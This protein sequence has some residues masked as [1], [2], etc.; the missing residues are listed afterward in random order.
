M[1]EDKVRVLFLVA[2]LNSGGIE[3]YLLRYLDYDSGL[4]AFVLCKTGE[5][6]DL[7]SKYMR[8]LG[9]NAI[10]KLKIGYFDIFSWI[11]LKRIIKKN[12]IDIVCDF[13]GNFAGIPMMIS[14][15]AGVSKRYTFYRGSTN[16]F[17]EDIFRL[18][19]NNWVRWLVKRYATR[20]LSNSEAAL[21]FFY[22]GWRVHN[23]RFDVI[24]N[25]IDDNFFL[26]EYDKRRVRNEL[27]IPQEAFVVGHTGRY[28]YAKN[29]KTIL[30][31]AKRLC[32][33]HKLLYFVLIGKG[34]EAHLKTEVDNWGL[35]EQIRILGYRD[36]IGRLLSCMDLFYFPSITE[37]QPNS[38]I[39][40]MV[41]GLPV[42]ASD[43][44]PVRE[45]IP[46]EMQETLVGAEDVD[47]AVNRIEEFY[48]SPQLM[49]RNIC[50]GW[51][52]KT[53][54]ANRQFE[55]FKYLLSNKD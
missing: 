52:R 49:V 20:I 2:S 35:S 13:S 24:Y 27:E 19:Y 37:G 7:E 17:K 30:A 8:R 26:E 36:D 5:G 21:D 54:S 3:N 23:V 34:T 12:K 41:K 16:H 14:A 43:I 47:M 48:N 15:Q 18:A 32:L 28:N 44:A 33:Q 45:C 46:G 40:A 22:P 51:A 50:T 11:K 53:F 1:S 42:L 29:H 10:I 25:G 6:G 4:S 38:L 39:E 31:V 55:K 9:N